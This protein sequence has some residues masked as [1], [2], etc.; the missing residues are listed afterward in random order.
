MSSGL[1]SYALG[2]ASGV[3]LRSLVE[4]PDRDTPEDIARGSDSESKDVL[5]LLREL[6]HRGFAHEDSNGRWSATDAGREAH[7][8]AADSAAGRRSPGT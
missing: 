6:A 3:I 2:A 1:P 4:H 8:N 5:Q 7:R